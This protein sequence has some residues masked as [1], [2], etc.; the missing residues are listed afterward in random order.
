MAT[1]QV[2]KLVAH[3]NTKQNSKDYKVMPLLSSQEP[4]LSLVDAPE[5]RRSM[6]TPCK[7]GYVKHT[8]TSFDPD[9]LTRFSMVDLCD[10]LLV[11]PITPNA[12]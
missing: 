11:N 6:S 3:L 8:A 10:P 2:E 9:L 12:S 7:L 4:C 5:R 1:Q